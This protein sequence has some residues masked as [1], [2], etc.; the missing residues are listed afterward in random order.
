MKSV[1]NILISPHLAFIQKKVTLPAKESGIVT[2]RDHKCR[3]QHCNP[4][5]IPP[6][7]STPHPRP[8]TV[9]TSALPTQLWPHYKGSISPWHGTYNQTPNARFPLADDRKLSF[10]G[11]R[12]AVPSCQ[13]KV[14]IHHTLCHSCSCGQADSM[15]DSTVLLE[16]KD[17]AKA[18]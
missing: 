18:G 13:H 17:A 16:L 12:V 6:F 14:P 4:A 2:T 11:G 1:F 5:L 3:E 8:G 15:V 7:S 9:P 10:V